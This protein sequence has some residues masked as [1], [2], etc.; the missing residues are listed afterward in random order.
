MAPAPQ[1]SVLKLQAKRLV[2]GCAGALLGAVVLAPL[3]SPVMVQGQQRWWERQAQA[4]PQA[5]RP[6]PP[7]TRE[8]EPAA[9]RQLSAPPTS[10][11]FDDFDDSIDEEIEAD[12]IRLVRGISERP[13]YAW[14]WQRVL[15][16]IRLESRFTAITAS[17]VDPDS[18]YL[19][20]DNYTIVR[21]LDGG[22][23]WD[24][25]ELSPFLNTARRLSSEAPNPPDLQGVLPDGFQIFVDPPYRERPPT[26]VRVPNQLGFSSFF[27]FSRP[28]ALGHA[29]LRTARFT[30]R[31]GGAGGE[32]VQV[33]AFSNSSEFGDTVGS[34]AQSVSSERSAN[35]GALG[36][37]SPSVNIGN[38]EYPGDLLRRAVVKGRSTEVVR[39]EVC[40]GAAFPLLV[41]TESEVLGSD[42]DGTTWARLFR[43]FGSARITHFDCNENQ[44]N[45]VAASTTAG[46]FY[47]LDG[48]LTFDQDLGSWPGRAATAV[49]VDPVVPNRVYIAVGRRMFA[50]DITDRNGSEWVYPDF[51]NTATAP[52]ERIT[53]ITPT[54]DGKLWLGTYNG[55]R[56]SR[57][58]GTSWENVA[59]LLFGNQRIPYVSTGENEI[60]GTRVACPV[61]NCHHQ[62]NGRR[63]CRRSLIMAS[64]DGGIEWFPFFDGA[65]RR[66]DMKLVSGPSKP[67]EGSR[68]WAASGGELWATVDPAI[69]RQHIDRDSQE[70]ARDR[71]LNS[72]TP[73]QATFAVLERLRLRE[74]DIVKARDQARARAWVPLVFVEAELSMEDFFRELSSAPNLALGAQDVFRT[75]DVELPDLEFRIFF[76]W[77]LAATAYYS[78]FMQTQSARDLGRPKRRSLLYGLSRG[79][80]F[81]VADAMHERDFLLARMAQGMSDRLHTEIFRARIESL[82]AVVETWME[83]PLDA[84]LRRYSE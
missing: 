68:W 26:R 67:G 14:R 7:Q 29:R 18:V 31:A 78:R 70:W 66:G 39:V 76:N 5:P 57:D 81:V 80:S 75:R 69:S 4:T 20:T 73:S 47:S 36:Y 32:A 49:G 44:P 51:N 77:D 62:W 74:T 41:A 3:I 33:Q 60:G 72:P 9:I 83:Q 50:G 61:R 52:W 21:T 37:V 48:G 11:D 22:V 27:N 30:A 71:I 25:I 1:P 43:S 79:V 58:R 17:P 28:A 16:V 8:P 46:A 45:V 55:L 54:T 42:D 10:D 15:S 23:T 13:E 56:V 6:H 34:S 63:R 82:E 40:P 65:V 64:D 59:P 24:S 35:A 53:W 38:T 19:G 84:S 12:Q 2:S